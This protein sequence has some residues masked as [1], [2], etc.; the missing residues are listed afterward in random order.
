MGKGNARL[1][2]WCGDRTLTLNMEDAL[3]SPVSLAMLAGA[4]L[5]DNGNEAGDRAIL[6]HV[7]G[8][9]DAVKKAEEGNTII[10]KVDLP[11]NGELATTE[12]VYYGLIDDNGNIPA[13]LTKLET[14]TTA[15]L[16]IPSAT[17]GQTYFVDYY[18]NAP[19]SATQNVFEVDIT[20]EVQTWNFYI[21]GATL[22]RDTNGKDHA[23][24]VII[25][26]GM[27]QSNFTISMAATG[28]PQ[29][30][31]FVVDAFPGYVKGDKKTKVMAAIQVQDTID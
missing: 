16:T 25:P 9:F 8:R 28:D 7:S 31:S 26:N 14:V 24:E 4:G 5:I 22:W 10:V 29:T 18:V 3:I 2:A 1:I 20:P 11:A 21:E 23:A 17:E 30:F 12:P 27:V 6:R 19:K 15:E 13:K